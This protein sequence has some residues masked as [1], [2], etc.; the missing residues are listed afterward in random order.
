MYKKV[1]ANTLAGYRQLVPE[2]QAAPEPPASA[3]ASPSPSFVALENAWKA[4]G[5]LAA[6]YNKPLWDET[7]ASGARQRAAAARSSTR[8]STILQQCAQLKPP[9]PAGYQK[10]ATFYW[11]KAYRDPTAHRRA[12]GGVRGQGPGGRRQGARAQARLLRGR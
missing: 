3:E 12:E 7:G 11:D 6:F 4:C 10:V 2:G 9:D 1:E 5:A 8:P